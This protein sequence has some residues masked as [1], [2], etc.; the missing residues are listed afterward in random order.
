LKKHFSKCRDSLKTQFFHITSHE[1]H[2]KAAMWLARIRGEE[3][4][5]KKAERELQANVQREQ[6][7]LEKQTAQTTKKRALL[8]QYE[9]DANKTRI[10]RIFKHCFCEMLKHNIPA[11]TLQKI[12]IAFG[13]LEE[14]IQQKIYWFVTHASRCPPPGPDFH[15][16]HHDVLVSP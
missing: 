11:M 6:G 12:G 7:K 13:F 8:D 1:G 14:R 15:P 5:R 16:S 2:G 9:K 10:K 4:G 3:C